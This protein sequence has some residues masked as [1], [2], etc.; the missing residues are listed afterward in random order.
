MYNFY[1]K[2]IISINPDIQTPKQERLSLTT[3]SLSP[4][5]SITKLSLA[6]PKK[7]RFSRSPLQDETNIKRSH[8]YKKE[9]HSVPLKPRM[10][11]EKLVHSPSEQEIIS[12]Q[13][14]QLVDR[15]TREFLFKYR[16]ILRE[17]FNLPHEDLE[18]TLSSD[19]H[20]SKFDIKFNGMLV[21]YIAPSWRRQV[22]SGYFIRSELQS[23]LQISRQ[24]ASLFSPS[25][26]ITPKLLQY[27]GY[28][29]MSTKEA[30]K[31]TAPLTLQNG[32][33]LLLSKSTGFVFHCLSISNSQPSDGISEPL[34]VDHKLGGYN[35]ATR[36][37][38]DKTISS[39]EPTRTFDEHTH[40]EMI[41]IDQLSY[42]LY[43]KI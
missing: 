31:G 16:D 11:Y 22:C 40:K 30:F 41:I 14:L 39:C 1:L 29:L 24:T 15:E 21:G 18:L 35:G 28:Q 32:D 43:R 17:I 6:T 4:L 34:I 12:H 3:S 27:L 20:P 23:K 25:R 9:E 10:L 8:P 5:N 7:S 36:D 33:K 26:L 19:K 13:S 42:H 37:T 2:K 38:W